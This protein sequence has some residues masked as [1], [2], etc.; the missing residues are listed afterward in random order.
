MDIVDAHTHFFAR[1]DFPDRWYHDKADQW[2]GKRWP[3]PST[4]GLP[5]RIEAGLL[6]ADAELLIA[7]LDAAGIGTAVTIG[8]DPWPAL[9]DDGPD[10][11]MRRIGAQ[12]AT[13]TTTDR[14]VGF[15]GVD[16]RRDEAV[17]IVRRAVT[18]HG[19]RGVKV[20]TPHGFHPG[21]PQCFPIYA[22]CVELDV[23]VMYHTA[24]ASF[25]LISEY[26]NPLLIQTV[27]RAFPD[28]SIILGHAG[29]PWWAEEA[30]FVCSG[31]ARTYLELSNWDELLA[32]QPDRLTETMAFMVAEVGAHRLLFGSDHHASPFDK[33]KLRSELV[34]W[35]EFAKEVDVFKP[36]EREL[37]LGDNIRRLLKL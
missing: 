35:V 2:A 24:R 33:G 14:L 15:V 7:D 27:Q 25:P 5:G 9:S 6:D 16:P 32:G 4:D 19:F 37:F 31:H 3:R 30:A 18:N 12:A 20:Y 28:L 36:G 11:L 34:K 8:L 26:A 1:G 13:I 21:D 10:D 29:Y 17:S 23:P 22:L